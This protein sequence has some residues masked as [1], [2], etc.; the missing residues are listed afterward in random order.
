MD[1]P[2]PA[3]TRA[4]IQ[5]PTKKKWE[6][7]VVFRL[8]PFYLQ[9]LDAVRGPLPRSLWA[10]QQVLSMGAARKG[11]WIPTGVHNA[12]PAPE[13]KRTASP[14]HFQVTTDE[15][16]TLQRWARAVKGR[17]SVNLWCQ[18]MLRSVLLQLWEQFSPEERAGIWSSVREEPAGRVT[19]GVFLSDDDLLVI[20]AARGTL[21][22]SHWIRSAAMT[23]IRMA[24]SPDGALLPGAPPD[25]QVIDHQTHPNRVKVL[26]SVEDARLLDSVRGDEPRSSTFYRYLAPYLRVAALLVS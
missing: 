26:L 17:Y 18:R 24:A 4:D 19:V 8:E 22:R 3:P 16:Q 11:Q 1:Q 20:D 13:G 15:F 23:A 2:A 5:K 6:A 14:F 7:E 21:R 25:C 12:P 10:R 9:I